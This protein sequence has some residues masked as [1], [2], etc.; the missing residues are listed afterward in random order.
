MNKT[1]NYIGLAQFFNFFFQ[2]DLERKFQDITSGNTVKISSLE[3]DRKY[4]ITRA[5]RIVTK[6]GGPPGEWRWEASHYP[7]AE[8]QHNAPSSWTA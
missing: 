1:Y 7:S 3:V 4:P 8:F 5:E 6:F 2:M